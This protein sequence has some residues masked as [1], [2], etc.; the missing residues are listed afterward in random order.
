[1]IIEQCETMINAL[2]SAGIDIEIYADEFCKQIALDPSERFFGDLVDALEDRIRE[3]GLIDIDTLEQMK[4]ARYEEWETKEEIKFS[5]AKL[6]VQ[7]LEGYGDAQ[8]RVIPLPEMLDNEEWGLDLDFLYM[9]H[10]MN[11][12]EY[13]DYQDPSG[14]VRFQ[15]APKISL[16]LNK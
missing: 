10:T 8:P 9:L 1:M 11:A 2:S 13:Y 5:D 15:K 3:A 4:W 6:L 12:G 7:W 14:V 16:T